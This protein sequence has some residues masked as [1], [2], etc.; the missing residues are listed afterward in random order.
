[1]FWP[2]KGR[3]ADKET[4][5]TGKVDHLNHPMEA[6]VSRETK[7]EFQI[8]IFSSL[9]AGRIIND[10]LL[11]WLY[12]VDWR[13]YLRELNGLTGVLGY[14]FSMVYDWRF[15][16]LRARARW[17]LEKRRFP[18]MTEAFGD[19][20]QRLIDQVELWEEIW[21]IEWETENLEIT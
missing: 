17:L 2:Y 21:S 3:H 6:L 12:N 10:G 7:F 4:A 16:M 5:R 9:Y 15:K 20:W 1:M 13:Q 8:G 11:A 18:T 19:E 14:P